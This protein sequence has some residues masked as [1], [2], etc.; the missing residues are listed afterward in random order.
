MPLP[1]S[2]ILG[3]GPFLFARFVFVRPILRSDG[4][5]PMHLQREAGKWGGKDGAAA[6]F[7]LIGRQDRDSGCTTHDNN[8]RRTLAVTL[9]GVSDAARE[10]G[11]PPMSPY[12]EM[13]VLP[14]LEFVPH[15]FRPSRLLHD[16]LC[17]TSAVQG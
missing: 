12:H 9:V 15:S 16:I 6:I 3:D 1:I 8:D 13:K 4:H 10:E 7:I 5:M 2:L 17:T 14:D 11:E